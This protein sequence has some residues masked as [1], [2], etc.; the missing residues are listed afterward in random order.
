M[1]S[2]W[3]AAQMSLVPGSAWSHDLLQGRRRIWSEL[4]SAASEPGGKGAR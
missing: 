1:V 3:Q 4:G 2:G